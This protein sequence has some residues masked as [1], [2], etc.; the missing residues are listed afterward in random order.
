[1]PTPPPCQGAI[2]FQVQKRRAAWPEGTTLCLEALPTCHRSFGFSR[3]YRLLHRIGGVASAACKTWAPL[4]D[5][6]CKPPQV[7]SHAPHTPLRGPSSDKLKIL[8]HQPLEHAETTRTP[9]LMAA[10]PEALR[11]ACF[12]HVLLGS[13]AG[14]FA[15]WLRPLWVGRDS[16]LF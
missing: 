5:A 16:S 3:S 2:C 15:H 13:C 1:M 6:C 9:S 4:G 12:L 11:V 8:Y 7:Q 10:T 14:G